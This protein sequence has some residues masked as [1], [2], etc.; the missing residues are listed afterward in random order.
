MRCLAPAGGF[1]SLNAVLGSSFDPSLVSQFERQLRS[2]FNDQPISLCSSGKQAIEI[3]SQFLSSKGYKKL[4]LGAYGCPDI[5]AAALRGGL[6]VELVDVNP[7]TL[8]PIFKDHNANEDVLLFS[9]LYGLVDSISGLSKYKIIDDACQAAFSFSQ[10]SRIGTRGLGVLSFGRGKAICGIGGGAIIGFDETPEIYPERIISLARLFG[11]SILEKPSLYCIPSCLPFLKLGETHFDPEYK[12]S[13]L[14]TGKI[15]T[16]FEAIKCFAHESQTRRNIQKLWI[17]ALNQQN[18]VLPLQQRQSETGAVVTRFPILIPRNRER[19]YAELA[20]A[21]VGAS[22][23]YPVDL[24]TLCRGYVTEGDFP[25]AKK[26]ASEIITLPTH[27]Y[28]SQNDV[29]K[30]SE[31]IKKYA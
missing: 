1:P 21:G 30:A 17:D 31:I 10:D 6:K 2:L 19:I 8:E 16:A 7:Q 5:V 4:V 14:T 13:L 29:S 25:G 15:A 27:R 22:I 24:N 18:V 28:V 23:S 3:I 11:Y 12:N 26:V 20:S 9:N